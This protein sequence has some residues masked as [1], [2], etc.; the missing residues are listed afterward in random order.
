MECEHAPDWD[1]RSDRPHSEWVRCAGTR[2]SDE[3]QFWTVEMLQGQI[4]TADRK[5]LRRSCPST[6]CPR[7]QTDR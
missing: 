2:Y 4:T 7:D 3:D 5:S 1:L 6:A